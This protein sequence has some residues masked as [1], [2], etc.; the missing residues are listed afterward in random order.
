MTGCDDEDLGSPTWGCTVQL[1]FNGHP[2]PVS[3]YLP[4]LM[5][6]CCQVSSCFIMSVLRG[7]FG[8]EAA[9]AGD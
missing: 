6:G 3:V 7:G 1:F 5:A 9:S 2:R 8:T 4:G